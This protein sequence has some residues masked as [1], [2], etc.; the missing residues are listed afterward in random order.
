MEDGAIDHGAGQ[1]SR[2][3]AA[4]G[5]QQIVTQNAAVMIEA[6]IVAHQEIMALTGD[7]HVL[8]AVE[9]QLDRL[10]RLMRKDLGYEFCRN[11]S[12]K[13]PVVAGPQIGSAHV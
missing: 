7:D 12:D 11:V 8:V 1:V 2:P 4:P 3:A 6:D 5:Q 10:L 9:P 13:N